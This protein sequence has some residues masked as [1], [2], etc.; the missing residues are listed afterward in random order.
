MRNSIELINLKRPEGFDVC[1]R[2]LHFANTEINHRGILFR[3][4]YIIITHLWVALAILFMSCE[5]KDPEQKSEII[6]ENIDI[7]PL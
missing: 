3:G 2:T 6:N 7:S 4:Q 5:Q 1:I